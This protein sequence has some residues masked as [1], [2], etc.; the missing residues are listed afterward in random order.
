MVLQEFALDPMA[1]SGARRANEYCKTQWFGTSL[2]WIQWLP[3]EPARRQNTVKHNGFA[4]V[5]S[6]SYGFLRSPP[7]DR[8]LY[9]T[10]VLQEFALDPMAASGACRA[11]EYCKTQWYWAKIAWAKMLVFQPIWAACNY[12]FKKC[13]TNLSP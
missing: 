13:G 10:M 1:A 7:G 12:L 2:L 3:Q 5:C 8:I 11:T 6:G 9:N 4:S